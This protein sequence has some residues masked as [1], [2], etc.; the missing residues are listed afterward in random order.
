MTKRTVLLSV[1]ALGLLVVL[2]GCAGNFLSPNQTALTAVRGTPPHLTKIAQLHGQS[3]G[4]IG[5]VASP[6]V[7]NGYLNGSGVNGYGD[8]DFYQVQGVTLGQTLVV[9]LC[10]SGNFDVGIWENGYWPGSGWNSQPYTGP[11]TVYATMNAPDN[12]YIF[13][14]AWNSDGDYQIT[15]GMTG[16]SL[17]NG[18]S[19][20]PPPV[21]GS[22]T[23]DVCSNIK[24][25]LQGVSTADS[26][27]IA[28][29][30]ATL[31]SATSGVDNS[32]L[33]GCVNSDANM[34][35]A[36]LAAFGEVAGKVADQSGLD[37]VSNYID[38][39]FGIIDPVKS[40]IDRFYNR[41]NQYC[42]VAYANAFANLGLGIP[43]GADQGQA[44]WLGEYY[45]YGFPPPTP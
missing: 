6:G 18:N 37:I 24:S 39:L 5:P 38:V 15:V 9:Q 17:N 14:G 33:G 30:M 3:R 27:N 21:V 32:T 40:L 29:A 23:Q 43:S 22:P 31:Q 1:A 45:C 34:A 28:A 25:A 26:S 44:Y 10:A 11:K 42:P 4:I 35:L 13:V 19:G 2:A 12:S 41:E 20:G 36:L 16:C 8:W 7:E